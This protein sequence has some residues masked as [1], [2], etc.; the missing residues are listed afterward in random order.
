MSMWARAI[1]FGT[2]GL[3]LVSATAWAAPQTG[4][5]QKCI[6]KINKDGDKVHEA[7]GG[8]NRA[9][10]KDFGKGTLGVLTGEMCLTADRKGKIAKNQAKTTGQ[11]TD[12]C[13]GSGSP[14][15]GYTG[16]ANV[17]TVTRQAEIDLMHKLFGNPVDGGLFA[18]D[19][20]VNQCVCQRNAINRIEKLMSV[21]P[22]IFVKCK[23]AA[24][25]LNDT[26]FPTGAAS[27]AD[28]QTCLDD[29]GTPESVAADS[30]TQIQ[31]VVDLL[32]GTLTDDCD[33]TSV[34]TVSFSGPACNG[35]SGTAARYCIVALVRCRVC[36]MINAEDG[37]SANCDLFDNAAADASC[38]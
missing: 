34:T 3:V 28:L 20:N 18:C 19:P 10:V 17:N 31:Q 33:A 13:G 25:K 6:N 9:C 15:F 16:A 1:L 21:M 24:L 27:A 29:P 26:P 37:L 22:R 2:A 38:P 14:G 30:G 23:K 11:A 36:L 12:F 5:Q 32:T 35:K 7:Q 4:D 8:D